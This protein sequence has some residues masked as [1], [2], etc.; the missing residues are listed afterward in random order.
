MSPTDEEYFDR[1]FRNAERFTEQALRGQLPP[2]HAA[3]SL[4][5]ASAAME[6]IFRES[7]DGKQ[8]ATF[9][10]VRAEVL[11]QCARLQALMASIPAGVTIPRSAQT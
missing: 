6:S 10:E 11:L 7:A 1:L 2:A 9:E 5:I 3:L 4:L 8:L